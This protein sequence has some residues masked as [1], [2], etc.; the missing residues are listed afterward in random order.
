MIRLSQYTIL[1]CFSGAE[2]RCCLLGLLGD[3]A[4]Q[5]PAS[6][7]D[8]LAALYDML[9]GIKAELLSSV[10][11]NAS[12]FLNACMKHAELTQSKIY[13]NREEDLLIVDNNMDQQA[14][15][16]DEQEVAEAIQGSN[17][18]EDNDD[19]NAQLPDV[20]VCVCKKRGLGAVYQ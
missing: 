17:V 16:I 18:N 14:L 6:V 3:V 15:P 1:I 12:D 19:Q 20:E 5:N 4:E 13:A 10:C 7:Y 9:S 11:E 2:L 8:E